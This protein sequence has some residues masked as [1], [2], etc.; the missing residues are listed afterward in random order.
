MT[1]IRLTIQAVAA[2]SALILLTGCMPE[3]DNGNPAQSGSSGTELLVDASSSTEYRGVNLSTGTEVRNLEN[4]TWHIAL[5][6]YDGVS[7]NDSVQA[8]LADA[9]SGFYDDDD[10]VIQSA[11]INATTDGYAADLSYP[12]VNTEL[13]FR[14][15]DFGP[16][17]GEWNEWGTYRRSLPADRG[18]YV[19]ATGNQYWV[20]QS[21]AGDHFAI[22]LVEN[23]TPLFDTRDK[24]FTDAEISLQIR[25]S[26][27]T[28][29]DTSPSADK[30]SAE[31]PAA[32][33]L[34]LDLDAETPAWSED[35]IS[36][37]DIEYSIR[38]SRGT[39]GLG[40]LR[41]NGGVTGDGGVAV[42][43]DSPM[44]A[45]DVAAVDTSV[46][47]FGRYFSV[48][49]MESNVFTDNPWFEYGINDAH[50]MWPNYR[51]YAVDIDGNTDTRDDIV[52]VQA[53]NYYHPD[54][55]ES[56]YI[57]LKTYQLDSE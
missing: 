27:A 42:H 8:A 21:S 12:Y 26:V 15:E 19:T 4:D 51:V 49:D 40:V 10:D 57:T 9:Q 33:A 38:V 18:G 30:A 47:E 44:N 37:W 32:G 6:R 3:D 56:G 55:G 16:A 52:L 53:T 50:K 24:S 35:Q 45:L 31:V 43:E 13:E 29:F 5:R 36:G 54:S 2:T 20:V 34:Y 46:P 25:P 22:N 28:G 14:G 39:G 1:Y 17:L 7:L 48:E 23:D 11:F 41:T